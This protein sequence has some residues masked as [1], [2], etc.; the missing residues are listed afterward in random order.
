LGKKEIIKYDEETKIMV[1]YQCCNTSKNFIYYKCNKRYY[2]CP[3][4]CKLDINKNELIIT[5]H[6]NPKIDHKILNLEQ[7]EK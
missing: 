3:G 7:F 5:K 4:A 1:K 6:C 2:K